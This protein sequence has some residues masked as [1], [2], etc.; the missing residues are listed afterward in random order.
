MEPA[1]PGQE[2]DQ[3]VHRGQQRT[4]PEYFTAILRSKG[5]ELNLVP[6]TDCH[7]VTNDLLT[8]REGRHAQQSAGG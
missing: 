6:H 7:T 8:F 5:Q 1:G 3:G 2:K 4:S